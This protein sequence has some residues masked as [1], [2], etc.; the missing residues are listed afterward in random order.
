MSAKLKR[1]NPERSLSL[2]SLL[3]L[4]TPRRSDNTAYHNSKLVIEAGFPSSSRILVE[5]KLSQRRR[6][7]TINQH[8][9]LLDNSGRRYQRCRGGAPEDVEFVVLD[10]YHVHTLVSA[11][12][13]PPSCLTSINYFEERRTE[14]N[15]SLAWAKYRDQRNRT[16]DVRH[17]QGDRRTA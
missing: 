15:T 12:L 9:G 17:G 1:Q 8:L 7:K 11:Q 10:G 13:S 14:R 3:L 6:V 16:F 4:S 5:R 2:L